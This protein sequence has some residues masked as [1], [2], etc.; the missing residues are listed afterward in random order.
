A[1]LN[2]TS[3]ESV[4]FKYDALGNRIERDYDA[5]GAGSGA[6]VV[7]KMA[8]DINGNAFLDMDSSLNVQTRRIST[9]AADAL[10]A[11]IG[12]SGNVRLGN[13]GKL[14]SVHF[15]LVKYKGEA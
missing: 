12:S 10:F 11:R 4:D 8:Y 9:E 3:I 2:G 5:D 6:P 14:V 1:S 13:W 7:L 15:L